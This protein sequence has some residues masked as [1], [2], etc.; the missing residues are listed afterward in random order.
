MFEDC[1]A[2]VA[3]SRVRTLEGVALLDWI[4]AKIKASNAASQEME[5]LRSSITNDEQF[6]TQMFRQQ[7]QKKWKED[8]WRETHKMN[9][10][11]GL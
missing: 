3:L 5:Q 4:S 10:D 6:N 9:Y 2:Y 11:M 1:M 8:W 7:L